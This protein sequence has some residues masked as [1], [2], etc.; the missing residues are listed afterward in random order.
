MKKGLRRFFNGPLPRRWVE[1]TRKGA[2]AAA[3]TTCLALTACASHTRPA[4]VQQFPPA[5]VSDLKSPIPSMAKLP[6]SAKLSDVMKA[7]LADAEAFQQLANEIRVWRQWW[8]DQSAAN[9]TPQQAQASVGARAKGPA[10]LLGWLK[11]NPK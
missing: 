8:A 3:A 1:A 2:F 4:L 10:S 7:H 9:A 11:R 6:D 5:P